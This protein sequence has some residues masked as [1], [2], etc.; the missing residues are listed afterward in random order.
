MMRM[1]NIIYQ[2]SKVFHVQC[3][4]DNETVYMRD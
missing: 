3:L 2:V 4:Y 1:S